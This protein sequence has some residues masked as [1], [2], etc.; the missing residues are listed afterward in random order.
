MPAC[1]SHV[2]ES[3]PLISTVHSACMPDPSHPSIAHLSPAVPFV[4]DAKSTIKLRALRHNSCLKLLTILTV[5]LVGILGWYI[6]DSWTTDSHEASKII[7]NPWGQAFGYFSAALYLS[8]RVPQLLLN[9]RRKSTEGISMLFFLFA[10]IGNLTYVLSI[11]FFKP[12]CRTEESLCSPDQLRQMYGR[13][14]AVN[15]S[16]LAGSAG[17]F[18]LDLLISAQFWLYRHLDNDK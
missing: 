5:I 2:H 10:C 9:Y 16:W 13:H 12:Q 11:L 14:V 15:A 18:L 3:S 8:S 7:F 1:T 4:S 6:T 17:T